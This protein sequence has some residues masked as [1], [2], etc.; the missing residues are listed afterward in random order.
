MLVTTRAIDDAWLRAARGRRRGRCG[1]CG[2]CGVPGGPP[3]ALTALLADVDTRATAWFVAEPPAGGGALV[4]GVMSPRS[5]YASVRVADDLRV[6]GGM[7]YDGAGAARE[8]AAGLTRQLEAFKANDMFASL[9]LGDVTFAVRD[10]DVVLELALGRTTAEM[11]I[12][13][14]ASQLGQLPAK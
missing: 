13:A 4:P 10:S 3:A 7:R 9:V 8:V 1:R 2:R 14:L 12:E 11:T 5:L 6:D